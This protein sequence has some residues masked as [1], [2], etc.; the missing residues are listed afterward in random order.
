MYAAGYIRETVFT[1]HYVS[2]NTETA[3]DAADAYYTLHSTMFLLILFLTIEV[4]NLSTSLHSTMFLLIPGGSPGGLAG[5]VFTFHYVS[6][7]TTV[8]IQLQHP[9]I[10]LYIPLCFY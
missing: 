8:R 3:S 7:N 10:Y 6:I 5:A 1:F 4:V 2:I 9:R